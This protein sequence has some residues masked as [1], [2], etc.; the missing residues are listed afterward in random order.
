MKTSFA[1]LP[2]DFVVK[3]N[4]AELMKFCSTD[5]D[6]NPE[7]DSLTDQ[8]LADIILDEMEEN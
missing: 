5:D 2:D 1:S 3:L 4:M 6:K 8:M 7:Q